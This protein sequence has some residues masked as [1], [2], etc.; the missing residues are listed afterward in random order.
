MVLSHLMLFF[1]CSA[2]Q[3]DVIVDL[4][5][6]KGDGL[7]VRDVIL[8]LRC[9]KSVHWVVKVHNVQG[10]LEVVVRKK[11]T[12]AHKLLHRKKSLLCVPL[13]KRFVTPRCVL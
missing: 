1:F 12:L 8:V 11:I 10:N 9:A 13:E 2:F 6:L 4:R 5:P 3:V 7:V